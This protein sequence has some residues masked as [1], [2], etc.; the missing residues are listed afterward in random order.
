MPSRGGLVP[1]HSATSWFEY[2]FDYD[3]P[4]GMMI[5]SIDL[6]MPLS[7]KA[8]SIVLAEGRILTGHSE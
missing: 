5:G 7:S 2:N 6:E 3:T 4:D 8:G 1:S